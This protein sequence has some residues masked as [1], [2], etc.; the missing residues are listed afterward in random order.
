M[1]G[2]K[3]APELSAARIHEGVKKPT[4]RGIYAASASVLHGCQEIS[5]LFAVLTHE[6]A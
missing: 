1:A 2:R 3:N 6:A 5:R 4:G